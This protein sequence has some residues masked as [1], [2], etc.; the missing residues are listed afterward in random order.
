MPDPVMTFL[1]KS[2]TVITHSHSCVNFMDDIWTDICLNFSVTRL[3]N[4]LRAK[5]SIVEANRRVG[6]EKV[7]L[8][9]RAEHSEITASSAHS[10]DLRGFE[11]EY[12][13]ECILF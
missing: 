9:E 7:T 11:S 1:T 6:I 8:K 4:M 2:H 12:D 3:Q 10:A 5:R 13:V